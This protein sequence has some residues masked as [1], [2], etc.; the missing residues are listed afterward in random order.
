MLS[1]EDLEEIAVV[2]K[3]AV[4]EALAEAGYPLRPMVAVPELV[5]NS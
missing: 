1:R 3:A 2:V 4:R 5:A